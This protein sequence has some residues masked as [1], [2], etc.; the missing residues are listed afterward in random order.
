MLHR[1]HLLASALAAALPAAAIRPAPA[2]GAARVSLLHLNDFHSRHEGA[3]ANGAGCRDGQA[4][5]GGSPRLVAAVKAA[6]AA[7]TAEGRASLALDAGDQFMGSLFYTHHRGLAEAAI[8]QAWGVEAMTLGNHE[9]DHGPENAARY[10]RALGAPVLAANLDTRD[11]PAMAGLVRSSVAFTRG[12]A[13]IV[14]IG[15]ITEETPVIASP[16]PRLRFTNAEE[17]TER[18]IA[19]ARAAGP[20]TIVLLSHRGF[21]PDRQLAARVR[22]VDVIVGGHSH[23]ILANRQGAA[24]PA[25]VVVDGPDRAVRIVQAGALGRFLGRLDLDIAADGR[26]T[27]HGGDAAEL[28]PDLPEDAEARAIVARFAAPLGELRTRPVASAQVAMG[29]D[30]CRREECAIGNVIAEAMLAAV[31][32]ADVALQNGG[33]IRAGMPSGTITYGDVLTTLPFGNTVATAVI[34]GAH[35]LAALENGLAQPGQGRFP[36]VAGIRVVADLSRPAGS[37]IVSAE[38][39]EGERRGPVDP[40]RAYRIVTN[41]FMRL[42]GDGYT[43]LRDHAL[44]AY[45]TGPLQE[46]VVAAWLAARS[47]L[48]PRTDGRITL[49]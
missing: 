19:E 20:A 22:G 30:T 1:R 44:E 49:R 26:V 36:Q 15:L 11:E 38:V 29:L 21:G 10:I 8:Q 17:A 5:L 12:G 6:R 41:N 14:V 7:A 28:T 31:P 43:A 32:G 34:R 42:G 25:P 33:G 23:T 37:R 2:Q 24:G 4:C 35:L 45:D 27:G 40:E 46:E 47:P 48:A 39:T 13:R 18:A 9:F 16:G 3:Q